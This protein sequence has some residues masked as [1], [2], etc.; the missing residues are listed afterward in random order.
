MYTYTY[1]YIHMATSGYF[2]C[3]VGHLV[4]K[5]LSSLFLVS[6]FGAA[7]HRPSRSA[8]MSLDPSKPGLDSIHVWTGFNASLDWI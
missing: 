8:M 4:R 1:T 2:L 7:A 3:E 6:L 5:G